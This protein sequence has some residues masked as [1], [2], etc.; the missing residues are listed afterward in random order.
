LVDRRLD[1]FGSALG[2]EMVVL[3]HRPVVE[4][5]AV[6][7]AAAIEH[8]WSRAVLVHH[9]EARTVER[10]GQALTNFA[11]R[12]PKAQSDLARESLKDPYRFD[13]L[14]IGD[15]ASEL[16]L[17]GALVKHITRFLLELGAGFA[18]VGRQVHLE[19][20]GEDFFL[21]L[22]FV[23]LFRLFC[24]LVVCLSFYFRL[25]IVFVVCLIC[26][27]RGLV[28]RTRINTVIPH[29]FRDAVAYIFHCRGSCPFSFSHFTLHPRFG[30]LVSLGLIQATDFLYCA[31]NVLLEVRWRFVLLFDLLVPDLYEVS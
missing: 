18:F 31:L 6:I 30:L 2:D 15:E 28:V 1:R 19:V 9:L 12:L 17:E 13:F 10:Q 14:G 26:S 27:G 21:D 22:L 20:G 4:A 7:C 8:G 11:E 5:E 3:H 29:P 24:L 16:E 23:C 25:L